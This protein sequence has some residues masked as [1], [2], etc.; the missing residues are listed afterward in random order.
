[1]T[2]ITQKKLAELIGVS[3]NSCIGYENSRREPQLS[4]AVILADTLNVSIDW[5]C[6]R[7]E[8]MKLE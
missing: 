3:V 5:L 4:R 1:M 2:G 6:G 8:K 7:S